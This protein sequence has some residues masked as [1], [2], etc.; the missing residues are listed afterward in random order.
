MLEWN[1]RESIIVDNCK[2]LSYSCEYLPVESEH[3]TVFCSLV[4]FFVKK[5]VG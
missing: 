5:Y 2:E 4:A 1:F 3:L